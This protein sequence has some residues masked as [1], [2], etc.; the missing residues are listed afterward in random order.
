MNDDEKTRKPLTAEEEALLQGLPPLT[1]LGPTRR[2][3]MAQ[4]TNCGL[5]ALALS[6]VEQQELLAQAAPGPVAP[7]LTGPGATKRGTVQRPDAV[8]GLAGRSARTRSSGRRDSLRPLD[9]PTPWERR[10]G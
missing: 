2:Q 8:R 10:A 4:V 9:S 5:G 7:P 1:D 6:L 3:F